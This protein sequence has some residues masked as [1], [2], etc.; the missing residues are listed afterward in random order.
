MIGLSLE[1]FIIKKSWISQRILNNIPLSE[2]ARRLPFSI[3]QQLLNPI[4]NEIQ[5]TYQQLNQA[6]VN[7][8]PSSFNIVTPSHVWYLD[9]DSTFDFEIEED[10]IMGNNIYVPP[11]VYATY[12]GSEHE[13]TIAP[14]NNI[15]TFTGNNIPTRVEDAG[16]SYTYLPVLPEALVSDIPSETL[17]DIVVD[18]HLYIT[19][20]NNKTWRH[21]FQEYIY[22]P[23][24]RITGI[25]RKRTEVTEE[26]PIQQNGTF[27]TINQWSSVSKIETYYLDDSTYVTVESFPFNADYM[28][29]LN[30][31]YISNNDQ[32][33]F[34]Y[35]KI[36]RNTNNNNN[37]DLIC[38]IDTIEDLDM[39]QALN[40]PKDAIYN[41]QLSDI[42]K[43]EPNL[44]ST[45][46]PFPNLIY[47]LGNAY[48]FVYD[49]RLPL[50]DC[51]KITE[52][53][54]ESNIDI[55]A[56]KWVAK[57]GETVKFSTRLLD[58]SNPPFR[59]RIK[60]EDDNGESWLGLDGNRYSTVSTDGWIQNEKWEINEWEDK[61]FSFE[62]EAY[63]ETIITFEGL[64]SDETLKNTYTKKSQF[65]FFSPSFDNEQR[66]TLPFTLRGAD[67]IGQ[68]SDGNLWFHYSGTIK[69]ATLHYDYFLVDY[70]K[71]RIWVREEYDELKVEV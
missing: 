59:F 27:K 16:V 39:A 52:D 10:K 11:Y 33:M 17:N 28:L 19:V 55:Y 61:I 63:E 26:V 65:L 23:K 53:Q 57:Y 64:Y 15:E 41:I 12:G 70:D 22:Y 32:E 54:P 1:R 47:I 45:M 8:H 21:E 48:F 40:F 18:G 30:N 69:K 62:I 56:D 3:A 2:N 38:Y 49:L 67:N 5:S 46:S 35:F 60:I 58:H 66:L 42:S 20:S 13:I 29:D 68:D 37:F 25:T 9:I 51:T 14:D 36:E 43:F 24:V 4:S 50:P 7:A 71:K 34:Q 31:I 6:K 44:S